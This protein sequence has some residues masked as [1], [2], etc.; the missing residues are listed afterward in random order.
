LIARFSGPA[1]RQ[2]RVLRARLRKNFPNGS[3]GRIQSGATIPPPDF[4]KNLARAIK[5]C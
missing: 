4:E 3:A 2:I 5:L 1:V